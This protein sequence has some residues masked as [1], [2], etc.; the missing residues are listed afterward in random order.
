MP[1]RTRA[2]AQ[3]DPSG[4]GSAGTSELSPRRQLLVEAAMRV[5]A[6]HGLKGLTHRAVD[7]EAGL[8]EGSCSAYLRTRKA[9][10]TALTE[11]VAGALT[12]DVERLSVQM[13]TCELGEDA[14]I[15]MVTG[16]FMG[17]VDQR[18]LL[19]ARMELSLEA[20]RDAEQAALL[21]ANRTRLIGLVES[22][23]T[24]RG[25]AHSEALAQT[26]VASFDG[27][28]FGALPRPPG[29]QGPFI[30]QSIEVLMRGLG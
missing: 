9:L 25:K 29:E 24:A 6:E 23:L 16:F 5:V 19:L 11:Y 18:E 30:R 27:I 8:P 22:I 13:S 12:A 28:L 26:L 1:P 3:D 15:E 4:A 17:W 21:S 20:S 14:A 7:R 2:T 10:V